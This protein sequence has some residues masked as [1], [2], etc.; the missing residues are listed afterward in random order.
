MWW[1]SISSGLELRAPPGVAAGSERAERVAVIALPPRDDVTALRL[2]DLDE[3]LPRHL[4]RGLDRLRAAADEI[5]VA[6]ARRSVLD[7][8]I[9]EPFGGLG[10]EK[11]R[12]GIGERVELFVHRG[13]HVGMAV[14]K[15]RD[16]R[17]AGCVEI[18][19]AIG[20][21]DLDPRTGDRDRHVNICSA[22]QYM[23][24]WRV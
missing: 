2:A 5:D 13:E 6:Q 8:P 16:R 9:R 12:V 4:E 15:A 24:H 23:R 14:A 1:V 18:A 19:P 22:V 17:A 20:V 21:D 10:G 7:Q 11:S 3:K